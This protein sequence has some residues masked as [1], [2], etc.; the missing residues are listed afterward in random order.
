MFPVSFARGVV[1]DHTTL[2]GGVFDPFCGRGTSV[3]CAAELGRHG[4][5][6]ELNPLGWIYGSAKLNPGNRDLVLARL[7]HLSSHSSDFVDQAAALPEFFQHCFC[8]NVREFLVAARSLLDWRSS[9]I[10]RTL[11]GF[12]LIYLHGKIAEG[13][14]NALSNQM[15][16]TKAMAPDYSVR[17]WLANG[18]GEPPEIDPLSFLRQRIRWRYEKGRPSFSAQVAE[19]RY[20]DCRTVTPRMRHSLVGK[21]QLLLTSPP[22]CGVTSYYYDQW[23][24][25]WLLGEA[26]RPARD[27]AWKSK[28]ENEASYLDLLDKAFVSSRRIMAE[29]ATIFVRTDKRSITLDATRKALKSAFPECSEEICDS[30]FPEETQT[31][32]F[33]DRSKKPGEVDILL[34]R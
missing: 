7:T 21:Y 22:Y 32:L 27:A 30:P 11:M 2:G 25:F 6:I 23:L 31:A 10:D 33:G 12:I 24:R 3:F 16:Q 29:D 17:W 26:D 5:G 1:L 34:R 14:P 13:K 18:F 28:F 8:L 19:V 15:R 9:R 4:T 20:G